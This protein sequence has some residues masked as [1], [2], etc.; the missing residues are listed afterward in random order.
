MGKAA[1]EAAQGDPIQHTE[2]TVTEP[3]MTGLND[4]TADHPDTAA[5]LVT[6]IRT[7]EDH[8]H[9]HPTNH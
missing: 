3:T 4:C 9:A 5:H 7:A 2:A 1:E 6:T 8:I